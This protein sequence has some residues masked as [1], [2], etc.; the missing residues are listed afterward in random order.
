MSGTQAALRITTMEPVADNERHLA[1]T[2]H[3]LWRVSHKKGH[4]LDKCPENGLA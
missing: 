4:S 1:C 2:A 3:S